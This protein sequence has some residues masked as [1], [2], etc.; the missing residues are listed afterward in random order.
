ME[1]NAFEGD[2]KPLECM[3]AIMQA[4]QSTRLPESYMTD[5]AVDAESLYSSTRIRQVIFGLRPCGTHIHVVSKSSF[6]EDAPDA[7]T[8]KLVRC[9]SKM[10]GTRVFV[11]ARERFGDRYTF[12]E[13]PAD[14][15]NAP[16][17]KKETS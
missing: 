13:I 15:A 4:V 7:N 6:M 3:H 5:L 12:S 9:W 14:K 17:P 11:I 2:L 10:D 16:V 8:R 1:I